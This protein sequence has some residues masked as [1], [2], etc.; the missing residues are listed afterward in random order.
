MRDN[1]TF[2][3]HGANPNA[4]DSSRRIPLILAAE[5]AKHVDDIF[6]LLIDAGTDVSLAGY[7]NV[8]ALHVAAARGVAVEQLL[9]AG[10]QIDVENLDGNTPLLIAC[11]QGNVD[12]AEKLLLRG[13]NVNKRNNKYK[14]CVHY[15]AIEGSGKCLRLVLGW[16]ADAF[17]K[18]FLGHSPLWY[19]VNS[20]HADVARQLL[21]MNCHIDCSPNRPLFPGSVLKLALDKNNVQ[22][23]KAF[24]QVGYGIFHIRQW[25]ENVPIVKWTDSD[26]EAINWLRMYLRQPFSMAQLCCLAVRHEL[27]HRL[28]SS[29]LALPL[30][31]CL[32]SFVTMED[33]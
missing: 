30:P 17:A 5:T 26:A 24:V 28:M 6:R 12:I 33:L 19:A 1:L 8:T 3:A 4:Q 14:N 15:A 10:A 27:G 32:I 18:D 16:G 25:T 29:A 7:G 11:S 20:S 31:K 22:I 23:L 9:E 21:K 13:A 2:V